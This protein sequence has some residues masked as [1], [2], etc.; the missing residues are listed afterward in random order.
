[1]EYKSRPDDNELITPEWLISIGMKELH[2]SGLVE[3]DFFDTKI[4]RQDVFLQFTFATD[5]WLAG[6]GPKKLKTPEFLW[7]SI[8][9]GRLWQR[10]YSEKQYIPTRGQVRMLCVAFNFE[11][12]D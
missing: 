1:M 10:K 8:N 4:E 2:K 3:Y 7:A 12:K 6:N 11:I 5:K 9:S